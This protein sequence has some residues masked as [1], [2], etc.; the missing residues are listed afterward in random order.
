MNNTTIYEG[1][2]DGNIDKTKIDALAVDEANLAEDDYIDE[3][4]IADVN[5]NGNPQQSWRTWRN[6]NEIWKKTQRIEAIARNKILRMLWEM[7]HTETWSNKGHINE[8]N[9]KKQQMLENDSKAEIKSR[10]Y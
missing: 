3:N 6:E 5:G 9:E 10:E 7:F 1:V 2:H 4:V 8:L